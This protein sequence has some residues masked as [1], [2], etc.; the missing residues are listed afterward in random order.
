MTKCEE[1]G[2][3]TYIIHINKD[4][5]KLCDEC[6]YK[7]GKG[8]CTMSLQEKFY[9]EGIIVDGHFKLN[10]GKHTD[11]Y[12]YKDKIY[13]NSELFN[14][15]VDELTTKILKSNLEIDCVASPS[16]GGVVLGAPVAIDLSK[17]LIYGEKNGEGFKLRKCFREFVTG[18]NIII[19]DDI[20]SSGKT[21]SLLQKVIDENGGNVVGVFCIWNRSMQIELSNRLFI[22][23]KSLVTLIIPAYDDSDCYQCEEGL[24]ITNLK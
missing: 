1:C 17:P 12:I 9:K 18:K 5:K 23:I 4:H 19:V 14:E 7:K 8:F 3:Y 11:K 10:S 21:I 6:Y 2:E 24:P 13:C 15:C 16:A 20:Y 22:G